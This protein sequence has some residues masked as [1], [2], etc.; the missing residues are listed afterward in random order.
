MRHNGQILIFMR[1][2][3]FSDGLMNARLGLVGCFPAAIAD[4]RP[5]EKRVGRRFEFIGGQKSCGAAVVFTQIRVA[6]YRQVPLRGK[7]ITR[8]LCLLFGA[9]PDMCNFRKIRTR[10]KDRRAFAAPDAQAPTRD[11]YVR[12][13]YDLG[14]C[15]DQQV[16][17]L[18][19]QQHRSLVS[20]T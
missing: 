15:D 12:I 5:G 3:N 16:W 18:I 2:D 1:L 6:A 20:K 10:R 13:D 8:F 4:I 17:H 11:W 7:D 9:G 19:R 14:M